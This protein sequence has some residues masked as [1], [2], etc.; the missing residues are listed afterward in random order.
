MHV[1]CLLFLLTGKLNPQSQH[2]GSRIS[3]TLSP[4]AIR[5]NNSLVF[6]S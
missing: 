6:E 3:P 1:G 2:S 5:E 4:I